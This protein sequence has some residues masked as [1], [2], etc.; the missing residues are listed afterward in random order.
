MRDF[1]EPFGL[2][3][4]AAMFIGGVQAPAW[5]AGIVGALIFLA[6]HLGAQRAA[7]TTAPVDGA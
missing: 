6:Y 4:V 2:C 7:V 1:G 5:I 3:L